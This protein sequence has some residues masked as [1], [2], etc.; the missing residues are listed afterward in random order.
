MRI[1]TWN[2]NSIRSREARLVRVLE[3]HAP[4]VVCLQELKVEAAKYPFELLQ[5]AGYTSLINA[6]K[7]YNG[8]A[9]LT[10]EPATDVVVGLNDGVED[11]QSRLIAATVRGVRIVNVYMPNGQTVGSDKWA[12]KLQWMRRLRAWLDQHES[13]SRPLALCGDF[14]VAPEPIDVHEPLQWEGE[15]LFHPDARAGLRDVASF[16]LVDAYR[17]LH[18]DEP[19]RFS[20]WDYRL[21]S[22][23]K[24]KG[25]RIDHLYVTPTLAERCTAATIDRDERKGEAP[26]D[27]APVFCDF[28]L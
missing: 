12:Y 2:V 17:R 7:T 23:P 26:S 1:A 19:G 14:N 25:L 22:F 24:G 21:L 16:G 5:S 9:I 28:D 20:W 15:T 3:R 8:V 4:D 11:P 6:Q 18:P 27:H 10:K 13:A